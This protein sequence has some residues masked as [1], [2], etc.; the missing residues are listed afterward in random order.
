M[1]TEKKLN[2][3]R[4]DYVHLRNDIREL[5][6]SRNNLIKRVEE[7]E[8][9]AF[10]KEEKE[11]F[12]VLKSKYLK[13]LGNGETI[14][15]RAMTIIT[16][17]D[18]NGA[19]ENGLINRLLKLEKQFFEKTVDIDKRITSLESV[20]LFKINSQKQVKE[21]RS[22]WNT[23]ISI[24]LGLISLATIFFNAFKK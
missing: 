2:E 5:Y 7:L 24:I 3:M 16:I 15:D 23:I 8:S 4:E 18:G 22:D 1:E 10:S 20:E 13:D 11:E 19:P 6:D 21:Q 9:R 17:L 14:Y 12:V